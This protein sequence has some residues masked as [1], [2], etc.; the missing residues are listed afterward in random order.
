VELYRA[1]RRVALAPLTR[2][3]SYNHVPQPHAVLYYSQRTTRGGLLI[4]E[5]TGISD[6]TYGYPS[7]PGIHKDEEVEAWK[8]IVKAVHDKGGIF[9]C[10]I[11][12]CGRASHTCTSLASLTT[13]VF[14][15]LK[16]TRNV[17]IT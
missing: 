6:D 16:P 7:T 12:H 8:P 10:Q 2:C 5:A 4:T 14:D 13:V 9:I 3:R 11:W 15:M 17:W 1:L